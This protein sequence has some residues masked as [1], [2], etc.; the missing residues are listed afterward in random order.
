[1]YSFLENVFF[2]LS[3]CILYFQFIDGYLLFSSFQVH[4]TFPLFLELR[5]QIYNW[6]DHRLDL[7]QIV[8]ANILVPKLCDLMTDS[9]S[10]AGSV[11]DM[12]ILGASPRP[13]EPTFR[14]TRPRNWLFQALLVILMHKKVWK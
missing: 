2:I 5:N 6:G 13:I 9:V 10:T 7:F 8:S 1:M 3:F 14:G 11:L 4:L 12:D